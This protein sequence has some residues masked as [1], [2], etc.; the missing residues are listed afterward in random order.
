MK[1][2]ISIA[3]VAVAVCACV[4]GPANES[5]EYAAATERPMEASWVPPLKDDTSEEIV[6]WVDGQVVTDW[7]AEVAKRERAIDGYLDD[8]DPVRA[9][10]YGFR[11]GQ[12]PRLAWSWFRNNPVGFNGVPYVLLQDDSRSRSERREPDAARHRSNLEAR[13][14]RAGRARERPQPAWTLDHIGVGPDPSDYVDGVARPAASASRRCRSDSRSRI[15]ARSSR[16]PRAETTAARRTAAGASRLSEHEPAHRQAA[17]GGQGGELGARPAGLR[18]PRRDGSRVL[19]VRGLP[20]RPRDGVREDEVPARHAQHGDRSAVL[21][22][23][24]DAHRARRSSSPASIPRPPT[25][26]NPA[27][28]KPNTSAIRAL[29]TEMLDKARLRP[30][31]LYGSSPAQIARGKIQTLAVADEFPSVMQDL[32]AVGVKTHFIYHVVARNNAYKRPL[33]D[34]FER[35]SRP[36]G[37]LWHRLGPGR[38]PHAPQGQQL[39]G[40]RASRQSGQPV[41]L[42]I[43]ESER[44]A[45]RH[46]RA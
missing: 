18:Q 25:P 38:D 27:G 33:P 12:N 30:E 24:A 46:R 8:A 43:L 17:D 29:Y 10:K 2:L 28:I 40:I 11:S 39:S 4:R 19:F 5:R 42:G 34:V 7:A 37:C 22:E 32:I 13:G 44:P 1:R 6:S 15:R 36:D 9:E 14:D 20:R 41:L 45:R 26:V 35:P 3:V 23:A 16:C 21:L 31:T